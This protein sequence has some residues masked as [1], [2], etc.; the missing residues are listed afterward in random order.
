MRM[1]AHV[2][3]SM[4]WC[5]LSLSM[6][7][8]PPCPSPQPPPCRNAPAAV[9]RAAVRHAVICTHDNAEA[10]DA[11]TVQAA[12]VALLCKSGAARRRRASA[13]AGHQGTG[14]LCGPTVECPELR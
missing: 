9:L 3:P 14:C 4:S 7:W 11:A 5:G 10:I 2:H 1:C 6:G 8:R 12:A 13:A